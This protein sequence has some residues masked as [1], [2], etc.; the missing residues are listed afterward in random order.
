MSVGGIV[1]HASSTV[2][3]I[4][5]M[6]IHHPR[7]P[8]Q[9]HVTVTAGLATVRP[10]RDEE[11]PARLVERAAQALQEAKMHMRGGLNQAPD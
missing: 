6:H 3:R 8:W 9:K 10:A 2:R 4:A 7:S 5:E 1:A 11:T